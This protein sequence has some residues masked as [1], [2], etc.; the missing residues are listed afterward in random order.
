M[1][2]SCSPCNSSFEV[3]L[4]VPEADVAVDLLVHVDVDSLDRNAHLVDPDV[5]IVDDCLLDVLVDLLTLDVLL[6]VEVC[7]HEICDDSIL[8]SAVDVGH[9]VIILM[10]SPIFKMS[11]MGSSFFIVF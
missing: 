9:L 6:F 10:W 2:S 1:F 11:S 3:D 5:K 7:I 4:E 8:F